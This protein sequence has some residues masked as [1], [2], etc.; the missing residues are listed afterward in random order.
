MGET[1]SVPPTH[2]TLWLKPNTAFSSW[3]AERAGWR[4]PTVLYGWQ[5]LRDNNKALLL[6]SEVPV[7]RPP[8]PP[9][10]PASAISAVVYISREGDSWSFCR[11]DPFFVVR[12]PS[13]VSVCERTCRSCVHTC[14]W[15]TYPANYAYLLARN[16][17][18]T[19]CSPISRRPN[20]VCL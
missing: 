17:L 15:E 7:S 8:L 14:N 6:I 16:I 19:L 11:V 2:A 4:I 9:K 13:G 20:S 3:P 5:H 18:G 1:V 12:P 10:V